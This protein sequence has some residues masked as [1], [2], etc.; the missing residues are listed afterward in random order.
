MREL[1][2]ADGPLGRTIIICR[3]RLHLDDRQRIAL[4]RDDIRFAI[5]RAEAIV[6]RDN[7]IAMPLKIAVREILSSAAGGESRVP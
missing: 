3:A 4:P 1:F 5:A 6:S 2:R 7:D